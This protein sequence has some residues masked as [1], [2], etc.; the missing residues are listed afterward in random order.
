[1]K[2]QGLNAP[3][4]VLNG[5]LADP[6]DNGTIALVDRVERD[7]ILDCPPAYI[8]PDGLTI[9]SDAR[10]ESSGQHAS[11]HGEGGSNP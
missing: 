8:R 11:K 9:I 3:D 10:L 6:R 1:M 2:P 4:A 7:H 5:V